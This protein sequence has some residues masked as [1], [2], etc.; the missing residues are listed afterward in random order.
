MTVGPVSLPR[1]RV[2]KGWNGAADT[3]AAVRHG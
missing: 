2:A 1:M 3:G